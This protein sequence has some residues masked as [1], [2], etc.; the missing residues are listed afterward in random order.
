MM[1]LQARPYISSL[2]SLLSALS[3]PGV[4]CVVE[5]PLVVFSN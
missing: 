3:V 4:L 5:T 1:R 2:C